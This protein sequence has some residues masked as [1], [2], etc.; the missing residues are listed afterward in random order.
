MVAG[1]LLSGN[2]LRTLGETVGTYEILIGT[3]V[4]GPNYEVTYIPAMLTIKAALVNPSLPTIITPPLLITGLATG[5]GTVAQ[6]LGAITEIP[7]AEAA[8]EPDVKGTDSNVV[9]GSS[10]KVC[11]WWWII[12]LALL[13]ALAFVG[14]S[15]RAAA[16]D[17][18]IRRYYYAWPPLFAGIAWLAHY[19]L[20]NGYKANWFCEN[21]WLVALLIAVLGEAT[22][23]YLAKSSEKE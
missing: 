16:K 22:Y 13:L 21:Y 3:L 17:D 15:V 2:L 20:H 19:F 1:D 23:W 7:V 6:V 10:D 14:G 9:M 12:G 18:F 5:A 4:A 11:P 8:E